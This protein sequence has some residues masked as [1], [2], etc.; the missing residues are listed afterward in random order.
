MLRCHSIAELYKAPSLYTAYSYGSFCQHAFL[1][2]LVLPTF[3]PCPQRLK[4][5]IIFHLTSLFLIYIFV[6]L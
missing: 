1:L 4:L 5:Q 2:D 6:N 3:T